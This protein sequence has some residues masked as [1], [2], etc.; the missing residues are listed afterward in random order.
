[1]GSRKGDGGLVDQVATQAKEEISL[2][3]RLGEGRFV[4]FLIVNR[5]AKNM[6]RFQVAKV[7]GVPVSQVNMIES[8]RDGDLTIA[9]IFR[10]ADAIGLSRKTV[11]AWIGTFPG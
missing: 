11:K 4:H 10:Y 3:Q 2:D 8:K 1:M 5:V 6:T 9:E 7:M